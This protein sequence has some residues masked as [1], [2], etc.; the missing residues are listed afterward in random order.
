MV[1]LIC[2]RKNAGKTARIRRLYE[3][4][5]KAAGFISEK[6]Y[7]ANE[8]TSYDLVDLTTGDRKTL[9]RLAALPMRE[10]PND[11][12]DHGP[13]YM[14]NESFEWAKA[15]LDKAKKTKAHAFFIDELGRVELS[16]RGHAR[17]IRRALS[18]EMDVYIS[19][20]DSNLP[21]AIEVFEI[22]EYRIIEVDG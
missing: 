10:D 7:D 16:G 22:E 12:F 3:E 15:C 4:Q 1:Y 6:H 11:V 21:D 20:R 19:V 8:V 17:L 14:F 18:S 2:G 13:F 5:E 9:A